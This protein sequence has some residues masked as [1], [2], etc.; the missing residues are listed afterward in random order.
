[1]NLGKNGEKWLGTLWDAANEEGI[2]S[3][4]DQDF[5]DDIFTRASLYGRRTNISVP[6]LD[7]L[8]R[9]AVKLDLRTMEHEEL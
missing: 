7:W 1:M 2:L 5:I 6:Q 8:N 9:I 3:S 4:K